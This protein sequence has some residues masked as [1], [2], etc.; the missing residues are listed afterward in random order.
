MASREKPPRG[1]VVG[2]SAG[3]VITAS[4]EGTGAGGGR[5]NPLVFENPRA[6]AE[7]LETERLAEERRLAGEGNEFIEARAERAF[8][9]ARREILAGG[10]SRVR[11]AT[12][13]L[14]SQGLADSRLGNRAL[15]AERAETSENIARVRTAIDVEAL[16][17]AFRAEQQAIQNMFQN[18]QGA[19]AF[20]RSRELL[21]M[22]LEAAARLAKDARKS[23]F[24]KSIGKG[25]F[26]IGKLAI[27]FATGGPAGLA[28]AAGLGAVNAAGGGGGSGGRTFND[29]DTAG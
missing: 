2:S 21:S 29:F 13:G 28:I 6:R 5:E 16:G 1:V 10:E 3:G 4:D 12:S 8:Q 27:G 24:L 20:Q 23:S 22:Q 14:A 26:S 18:G 9:G 11:S 25:I 15:R 19:L 7:R 17:E